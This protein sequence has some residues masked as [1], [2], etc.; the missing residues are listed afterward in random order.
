[1]SSFLVNKL[2][3]KNNTQYIIIL[4]IIF[5][6][7]FIFSHI[8]ELTKLTIDYNTYYDYGIYLKKICG[9]EYLEA[10]T[11]R[12]QL[13]HNINN[14]LINI[15]KKNYYTFI[16]IV[17]IIISLIISTLFSYV[18][19]NLFINQKWFNKLTGRPI[20]YSFDEYIKTHSSQNFFT[21][22]WYIFKY[23]ILNT[24]YNI[25]LNPFKNIKTILSTIIFNKESDYGNDIITKILFLCMIILLYICIICIFLL[26]PLYIGLELNESKNISPFNKDN[27]QYIGYIIFFV[28][29]IIFRLFYWYFQYNEGES[30]NPFK[31]YFESNIDNLYLGND[32]SG[33]ILF[34]TLLAIYICI[35]YILGNIIHL[36]RKE[37]NEEYK[38]KYPN[39]N[40]I[41][42]KL[43]NINIRDNIYYTFLNKIFG[44]KEYYNFDVENVYIKNMS[45]MICT[46]II[47][48]FVLY[49]ILFITNLIGNSENNNNLLK[50]GIIAPLVVLLIIM[51]L[52]NSIFEYNNLINTYILDYP[53]NIYN[54][55]L[56][57]INNHVNDIMISKEYNQQQSQLSGGY[58]SRNYGN[59]ILL[60]LY[61]NFFKQINEIILKSKKIKTS[62]INLTPE[63]IYDNI[64]NNMNS[65]DFQNRDEYKIEYY[66]N[67][68][69]LNK[70]IFY[71]F[72][73]CSEPNTEVIKVY[74][75]KIIR[76]LNDLTP[77][78]EFGYEI[79]KNEFVI[80]LMYKVYKEFYIS[81]EEYKKYLD[82]NS[83]N[84]NSLKYIQFM[85]NKLMNDTKNNNSFNNIINNQK[86]S[87]INDIKAALDNVKNHKIYSNKNISY[88]YINE[89]NNKYYQHNDS[90]S[91]EPITINN[92]NIMSIHNHN[93]K[94]LNSNTIIS[95]NKFDE[96]T[97]DKLFDEIAEIYIEI[98]YALLY[99][100]SPF[101]NKWIN[102]DKIIS[103]NNIENIINN[104]NP[105][106]DITK[107]N[108]DI[109]KKDKYFNKDISNFP[110]INEILTRWIENNNKLKTDKKSLE[111]NKGTLSDTNIQSK[112]TNIRNMQSNIIS[113]KNELL[114][115]IFEHIKKSSINID[116]QT[117]LND[118]LSNDYKSLQD[119]FIEKFTSFVKDIFNRINIVLSKYTI[120]NKK[121]PLTK[122][123][124]TN[125]NNIYLDNTYTKDTF[126]ILNLNNDD[127]I[128]EINIKIMK[129]YKM[130]LDSYDDIYNNVLKCIKIINENGTETNEFKIIIPKILY[131]I[132]SL[133]KEYTTFGDK[134]VEIINKDKPTTYKQYKIFIN[135]NLDNTSIL[136]DSRYF[137]S[138]ST[139]E[140]PE[141]IDG[142]EIMFKV[143]NFQSVD[144]NFQSIDVNTYNITLYMIYICENL[145]KYYNIKYIIKPEKDINY[146]DMVLKSINI[147][148]TNTSYLKMLYYKYEND[149]N[150]IK[151]SKILENIND[152][153]KDLSL[154]IHK[155][156][157]V[158]DKSIYIVICNY[159]IAVLLANI[160]II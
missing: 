86:T 41:D 127:K 143:Q 56:N 134:T 151:N 46:I 155:E 119:E 29:I 90:A 145:L 14:L 61:S 103:Y 136:F 28:V 122:Y 92:M 111:D 102:E 112:E 80:N 36:Y 148:K 62:S 126:D 81:S 120:N 139:K 123:I 78:D 117:I 135:D 19:Y 64:A 129:E 131:K 132:S 16:L 25:V 5:I 107:Y 40:D 69:A 1:M 91:S 12:F 109:F 26:M 68:K 85:L 30:Y 63:F 21:N 87:F 3:N 77:F 99:C 27:L 110:K 137:Q 158:I 121:Y 49:F 35:F 42:N 108:N 79:P 96:T 104:E 106:Y 153:N 7:Y 6:T 101:Y 59:A 65:F 105:D 113:D 141:S 100:I 147:L 97:Y 114:K 72:N 74:F 58:I 17:A 94:L 9:Q 144:V 124:I 93:N 13:Y 39:D 156:I 66:L 32:I 57:L 4:L 38:T 160:I 60:V 98:N 83:E 142:N 31:E 45:G 116:Y 11:P 89:N 54:K 130:Y 84:K 140:L 95:N 23:Y 71:N 125:Y 34:F 154:N 20:I 133:I 51:F 48:L 52:P 44:Y 55:Y 67:N 33:Y 149:K 157:Q 2:L 146:D 150:N 24:F 88:I 76:I 22:L 152:F 53:K 50:Y 128:K 75:E 37:N 15:N 43:Q 115:L 138:K 118:F 82:G 8:I 10:E 70:N 18:S 73:K 47:I 159:V